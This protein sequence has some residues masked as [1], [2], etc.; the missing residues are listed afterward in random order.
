MLPR[1]EFPE[2]DFVL[3]QKQGYTLRRV[4]QMMA[5][6]YHVRL[7]ET[8]EI[9]RV[10]INNLE[11]HPELNWIPWIHFNRYIVGR[12]NL[13]YIPIKIRKGFSNPILNMGG[14]LYQ[15]IHGVQVY[16]YND[17][18]PTTFEIDPHN[19]TCSRGY[20]LGDLMNTFPDGVVLHPRYEKHLTAN[21]FR[22]KANTIKK[23]MEAVKFQGKVEEVKTG[24]SLEELH[25]LG[26]GGDILL[27]KEKQLRTEETEGDSSE[28]KGK[29]MF[30]YLVDKEQR[31]DD[32]DIND[33]D[34]E[35]IEKTYAQ[36]KREEKLAKKAELKKKMGLKTP[37]GN[38]KKAILEE[39]S[40]KENFKEKKEGKDK[41]GGEPPV[42]KEK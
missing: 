23:M 10:T 26:G 28:K 37:F 33:A 32:K 5:Q 38:M 1:E 40:L 31:I 24:Q 12:P 39:Y 42:T 9:I 22:L 34:V 25:L 4:P 16:S 7:P 36:K 6:N 2:V 21:I 35:E 14:N 19:V 11:F 3:D 41:K 27:D 20:R 29:T 17:D 18:Y 30:D 15:K 8:D 13:L